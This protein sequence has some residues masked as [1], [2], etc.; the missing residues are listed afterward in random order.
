MVVME[1]LQATENKRRI[2]ESFRKICVEYLPVMVIYLI[3]AL[4]VF[5]PVTLHITTTVAAGNAGLSLPGTGD[6]YQNLW[7]MWWVN[8]AIFGL[9]ISPYHTN[10]LFYPVG[11]SLVTETLSPLAGIYSLVFQYVN[12][13]FAFNILLFTD[14]ALCGLFMFL[15][16]DHIIKNRYAAFIAG[17]IF[18]FSPFHMVHTLEGQTNWIGIQF[19]PLLILFF[20]LMIKDKKLYTVLGTSIS[21]VLLIFYGDPEEGILS[22]VFILLLL[23]FSMLS[24]S[25]RKDILNKRFLACLFSSLVLTFILGSPF[26]LPIMHGILHGT[27][28]TQA[29]Y[30]ST[31]TNSMI[32]STPLLS[33][34]LPPLYNNLFIPA[35]YFYYGVYAVDT[36]ERVAYLGWIVIFLAAVAIIKDVQRNKLRNLWLW[37][38]LGM[39]FALIA[40]GPYLQIGALTQQ[41]ASGNG[42]P[43]IYLIY[44][45]IPI[46]NLVREPGRFSLMVILCIGLLA[47]FGLKEIINHI[48]IEDA[49]KRTRTVQYITLFVAILIL[50]EYTGIPFRSAYINQNFIK[51]API[52]TAYQQLANVPGNYSVMFLPILS[53]HTGRPNLFTGESEY[54]ETAFGKPILGGYVTRENSSQEYSRLNIPLSVAAGSLQ[55]GGIFAYSSAINENYTNLTLFFLSRY[56]TRFI[57][58]INSAYNFSDQLILDDYLNSLFGTPAYK[59]NAT[60]I[61]SVNGTVQ[62]ANGRAINAYISLGNWTYGCSALGKILCNSTMDKLWYGPNLRAINVSVPASK[63]KLY[64][65]F[66]AASLNNNVTLYVFQTSD[67]NELGS[68]I[69]THH[70]AN[71]SVNL[72][73]SPGLNSL[74]LV[75]TNS[76]APV[77]SQAFDLGISNITFRER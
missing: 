72:T 33:F 59:D 37:V 27:A 73:L 50:I 67:K 28:L 38:I 64:M 55:A 65:K 54:Y 3:I 23:F 74:F 18:T 36:V 13:A 4:V 56:N 2:T 7:S 49:K 35:S 20:L 71:Y 62:R 15:L 17:L 69:L 39:I 34:F 46:L 42:I 45:Q 63:T 41:A 75:A 16:A 32:W 48:N 12:L 40:I 53:S 52:S 9:Y 31:I 68:T 70:I 44:R 19:I 21:F 77:T 6:L 57:S 76:T 24:T 22:I 29:S 25:R 8:K 66:S 43:G 5:W 26:L 14:F 60:S 47:G 51:I 58:L 11:A 61:W 10:L 1:E 30:A